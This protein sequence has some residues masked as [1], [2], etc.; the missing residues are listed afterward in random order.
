MTMMVNGHDH[1]HGDLW[2][3]NC[4]MIIGYCDD[5]NYHDTDN[6]DHI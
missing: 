6:Y 3:I 4:D 1:N 2:G 5:N